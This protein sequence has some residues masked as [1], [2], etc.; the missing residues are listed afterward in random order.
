MR[1]SPGSIQEQ[2]M[3]FNEAVLD[4][5]YEIGK[6]NGLINFCKK[7]GFEL[8]DWVKIREQRKLINP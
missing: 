6:S 8:K 4:L 3:I 5:C 7:M 2:A 1:P